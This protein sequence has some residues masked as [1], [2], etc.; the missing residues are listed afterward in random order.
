MEH[1]SRTSLILGEDAV[2]ALRNCRVAI[3]GVGGVG[4]HAMEARLVDRK[5]VV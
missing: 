1:L 2:K 3:F 5:S 4:G